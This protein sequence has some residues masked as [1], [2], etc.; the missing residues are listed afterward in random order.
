MIFN[1]DAVKLCDEGSGVPQFRLGSIATLTSR[2]ASSQVGTPH[3]WDK[4]SPHAFPFALPDSSSG[5]CARSWGCTCDRTTL[6][7]ETGTP[8]CTCATMW[9][10]STT[11]SSTFWPPAVL[12]VA[13]VWNQCTCDC[14]GLMVLKLVKGHWKSCDVLN[15]NRDLFFIRS[16]FSSSFLHFKQILNICSITREILSSCWLI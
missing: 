15:L 7:P 1:A 16:F 3:T 10:S 6:G 11:T 2:S 13:P 14:E 5:L 9:P 8:R 12:W 4:L